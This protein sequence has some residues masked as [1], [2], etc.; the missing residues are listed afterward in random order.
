[1]NPCN[2]KSRGVWKK[3]RGLSGI[4]ASSLG[5]IRAD[6]SVLTA[7][8]IPGDGLYVP[9]ECRGAKVWLPAHILVALTHLPQRPRYS[10]FE[11]V[12]YLTRLVEHKNAD[13]VDNRATNLQWVEYPGDDDYESHMR[14]PRY[15]APSRM[16]LIG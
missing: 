1:E 11:I 6:E 12:S 4:F 10:W 8:Y 7:R 9:V 13:V 15:G 3:V 16:R 5:A 14:A 2:N